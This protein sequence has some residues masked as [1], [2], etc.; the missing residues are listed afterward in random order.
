MKEE[1]KEKGSSKKKKEKY[2]P[3]D[4]R[5]LYD[6]KYNALKET[7]L[8]LAKGIT[9]YITIFIGI[10]GYVLTRQDNEETTKNVALITIVCMSFAIL[11][12]ALSI[13]WGLAKGLKSLRDLLEISNPKLYKELDVYHLFKRGKRVIFMV[14]ISCVTVLLALV[15]AIIRLT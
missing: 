6:F 5:L 12:A 7:A 11:V 15:Y 14:F 10:I 8:V 9:F 3:E 2:P 13:I 4:I 1:E